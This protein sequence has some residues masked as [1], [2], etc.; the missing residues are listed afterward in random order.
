MK[1]TR[2]NGQAITKDHLASCTGGQWP[3]S[4]T[5]LVK[6]VSN[7]RWPSNEI[8]RNEMH[9]EMT[10]HCVLSAWDR[11]EQ[12]LRI[13]LLKKIADPYEVDDLLQELFLK[14]I[15]QS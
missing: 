6:R 2:K 9:P 15:T 8:L 13:F 10:H 11:H 1:S 5:M 3:P 14:L 12:E 7:V 4:A